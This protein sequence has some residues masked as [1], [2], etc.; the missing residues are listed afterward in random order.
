MGDT[1][2]YRNYDKL[3]VGSLMVSFKMFM[4]CIISTRDLYQFG[5]KIILKNKQKTKLKT[6]LWPKRCFLF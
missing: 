6:L 4:V 1:S 2:M 5:H 3:D